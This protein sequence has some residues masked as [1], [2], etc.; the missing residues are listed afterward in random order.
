M[1]AQVAASECIGHERVPAGDIEG[2]PG[3]RQHAG[4]KGGFDESLHIGRAALDRGRGVP[5]I[6]HFQLGRWID[7]PNINIGDFWR[8]QRARASLQCANTTKESSWRASRQLPQ[9]HIQRDRLA[10]QVYS[11]RTLRISPDECAVHLPL[12]ISRTGRQRVARPKQGQRC[13]RDIAQ[14]TS[15]FQF[16][17]PS[18]QI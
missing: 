13:D 7:Y 17:T 3:Q 9:A 15:P 10:V 5:P 11:L 8:V 2:H 6:D 16:F 1:T 12:K 4:R 18:P 14:S